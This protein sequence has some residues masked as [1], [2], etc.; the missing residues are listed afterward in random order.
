MNF[1]GFQPDV[2]PLFRGSFA[3]FLGGL[4]SETAMTAECLIPQLTDR[5]IREKRGSV[6]VL[7][8]PARWYGVTYREDLPGVSAAIA[9][10]EAGRGPTRT[11]YG[12]TPENRGFPCQL[13][14]F[15]RNV[16]CC[17]SISSR[18]PD[19]KEVGKLAADLFEALIRTKPR[20]V[21]GLATGSTPL[22]LYRELIAREK[23]RQDRLYPRPFGHLD[24]YKGLAPD[25]P[26]SLSPLYAGKPLRPHLHQAREHH[27]SRRPARGRP[28]DVRG[29]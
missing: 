7:T 3:A 24:E 20:C 5:M 15:R 16:I 4:T 25:H 11:S 9:A 21:I 10:L 2:L 1:W 12:K 14:F 28:G 8:T 19:P 29:V 27:R 26:Q 18:L 13:S 22:P 6:Q 23:G 17:M